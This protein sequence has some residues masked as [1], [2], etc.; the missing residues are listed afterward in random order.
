[1]DTIKNQQTYIDRLCFQS[2]I[3]PGLKD[4]EEVDKLTEETNLLKVE[5]A[6]LKA[7]LTAKENGSKWSGGGGEGAVLQRLDEQQEV[8]VEMRS[9]IE[10]QVRT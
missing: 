1:M 5:L 8:I 10:Y 6:K 9:M 2:K 3:K 4:Q 7:G